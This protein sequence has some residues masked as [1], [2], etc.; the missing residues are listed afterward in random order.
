MKSYSSLLFS[1]LLFVASNSLVIAD[2][3]HDAFS[4]SAYDTTKWQSVG[5]SSGYGLVVNSGLTLT[6]NTTS[7]S[8]TWLHANSNNYGFVG[9]TS[10]GGPSMAST[11]F[12]I[13]IDAITASGGSSVHY[14]RIKAY[15]LGNDSTTANLAQSSPI[16]GAPTVLDIEFVENGAG[17]YQLFLNAKASRSNSNPTA[18]ATLPG[19]YTLPCIIGLNVSN[20]G[21]SNSSSTVKIY[22]GTTTLSYTLP[23]TYSSYFVN[24]TGTGVHFFLESG[25][26]GTAGSFQTASISSVGVGATPQMPTYGSWTSSH[27]GGGGYLQNI[28]FCPSNLNRLYTYVDMAGVYRSDDGGNSWRMIMGGMEKNIIYEIRTVDVDPTNA[29][30]LLVAIHPYNTSTSIYR[31]TN[32]GTSWTP[33]LTDSNAHFYGNGSIFRTDGVLIVRKP[34]SPNQVIAATQNNSTGSIYTSSDGGATWTATG[35]LPNLWPG[36]LLVDRSN[37]NHVWLWS[38]GGTVNG[39]GPFSGGFYQSYDFGQTWS[40][41]TTNFY[42][43]QSPNH[44]VQDPSTASVLWATG[45]IIN[46]SAPYNNSSGYNN[47]LVGKSTDGGQTWSTVMNGLPSSTTSQS[48]CSTYTYNA[49]DAYS[50]SGTK[51]LAVKSANGDVYKLLAGASTWTAIPHTID[52]GDYGFAQGSLSTFG[53]SC[54]WLRIDPNNSNRWFSS[55]WYEVWQTLDSGATWKLS[56]QGIENTYIADIHPDLA[57]PNM[58]QVSM[59]D[60]GGFLSSDGGKS[61]LNQAHLGD[62]SCIDSYG[63]LVVAACGYSWTINTVWISNDHG[64]TWSVSPMTGLPGVCG[65]YPWLYMANNVCESVTIDPH[66][67]YIYLP[68]SGP[69]APG[70]GGPYISKDGGNTWDWIGNGLPTGTTKSFCYDTFMGPRSG[71]EIVVGQDGTILMSSFNNNLLYKFNPATNTWS[72][73]PT[74]SSGSTY[75]IIAADPNQAGVFYAARGPWCGGL[76]KSINNGASWTQINWWNVSSIGVD[77]LKPGCLVVYNATDAAPYYSSDS[78]TTWTNLDSTGQL[79]WKGYGRVATAGG[80]VYFGAGGSGLFWTKTP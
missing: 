66:T 6:T 77:P 67:G 19:T 55:D 38:R 62:V 60:N 75:L 73:L 59:S 44:I 5:G 29:D 58:V 39:C 8:S 76:Y 28:V 4:G 37:S 2:P 10:A 45:S 70:N 57:C 80:L 21:G 35:Q 20:S 22:A 78:G 64:I 46:S 53:D 65:G 61:F 32:G 25:N 14:G 27:I 71:H 41:I 1:L 31:S 47:L 51:F 43:N 3:F 79:P 16:Y 42:N 15:L 18:L 12:T 68:V 40:R 56:S 30:N 13:S 69:I 52:G 74:P 24:N 9:N 7:W 17:R 26:G 48:S 72:Q 33:V 23:A 63:S 50:G 49:I 54:G 11:G 34:G 36:G